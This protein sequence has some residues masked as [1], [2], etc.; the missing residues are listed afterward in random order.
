MRKTATTATKEESETAS[1]P[2]GRCGDARQVIH[3]HTR[4]ANQI[5]LTSGSSF[6]FKARF[7]VKNG[8]VHATS[9]QTTANISSAC[10]CPEIAAD[11]PADPL[12]FSGHSPSVRTSHPASGGEIVPKTNPDTTFTHLPSQVRGHSLF[13]LFLLTVY[14]LSLPAHPILHARD[15]R[16]MTHVFC[17]FCICTSFT[18]ETD[19]RAI[20]T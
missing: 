7:E 4:A 11:P 6:G 2:K 20:G 18:A 17:N 15:S 13:P 14:S 1:D 9:R 3:F 8:S 12:P 19:A 10:I 5:L 16:A